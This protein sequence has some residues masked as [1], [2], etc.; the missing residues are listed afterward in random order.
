[1]PVDA[2]G[3]PA[4]ILERTTLTVR[5]AFGPYGHQTYGPALNRGG[6]RVRVNWRVTPPGARLEATAELGLDTATPRTL[7]RNGRVRR[8][9]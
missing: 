4:S 3:V 1:M 5:I 2:V 8:G 7:P 9:V 6:G